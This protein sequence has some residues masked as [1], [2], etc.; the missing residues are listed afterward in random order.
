MSTTQET[1]R[2]K[3]ALSGDDS[4]SESGLNINYM[5]DWSYGV[6]ETLNL[7]IPNLYGGSGGTDVG[8][9]S[10]TYKAARSRGEQVARQMS[11][12]AP[13]YWGSQPFTGGPHYVGAITIFLAIL[14]LFL[15]RGPKK[16]WLLIIILLSFMLAWGRNFMVLTE[17][18]AYNVPLYNKFRD[19]TNVL[20]IAQFALPF[21]AFLGI[22]SW[23][24]DE[25]RSPEE[26]LK[27]LYYATGI[28][29]GLAVIFILIP[30]MFLS[31]S[32]PQDAL[33]QSRGFSPEALR[34]DRITLARIDSFRTLVFVLLGSGLLW[35]SIKWKV[36]QVY[37][38]GGLA[39]LIL[40]DLWAVDRRYLN[41]DNFISPRQLE[42]STAAAPADQAI[43]QDK[44]I[45]YRVLDMSSRD[46][47][48]YSRPSKFHKSL[49]GYHGA[50]LGRYQ[51]LIDKKL[52]PEWQQFTTA[53]GTGA[54][55][56]SVTDSMS[57]MSAYNM[58]NTRYIIM[59]LQQQP[60]RNPH[61]LGNAWFTDNIQI[62]GSSAEE[63]ESI[64]KYDLGFT[65]LVNEEFSSQLKDINT[66]TPTAPSEIIKLLELK[67]NYL[68]YSAHAARR[69]VWLCSLKYGIL[70]AGRHSLTGNLLNISVPI[71]FSGLLWSRQVTMKLSSALFR[72]H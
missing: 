2:G 62:V 36:K 23:F 14:G 58:L 5:T 43:L 4:A 42:Q 21:L 57:S 54:T 6:G 61:A 11:E 68:K 35:I 32:G 31:F 47:F 34:L 19:M 26:K 9:N 25:K 3:T 10:E 45:S 8:T 37:L 48:K 60:L 55:L 67:P 50:K 22:R 16:W 20:I 65:A 33:F 66:S 63:L 39:F 13:T 17:F 15:I 30:A 64:S 40:I 59:E 72:H 56:Q 24:Y 49:G 53:F 46:P 27:K 41:T 44:S 70:T 29:G 71:I 12:A 18:F 69:T 7:F 28:A 52:I 1:T 51:D 38:F